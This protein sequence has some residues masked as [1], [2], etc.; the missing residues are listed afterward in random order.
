MGVFKK[1]TVL[2]Y[3]SWIL[4]GIIFCGKLNIFRS[5]TVG[6]AKPKIWSDL[7]GILD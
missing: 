5:W 6:R 2:E 7:L 4:L 3:M 1:K